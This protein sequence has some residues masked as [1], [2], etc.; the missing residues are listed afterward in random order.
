VVC[1]CLGLADPRT[2]GSKNPGTTNV[3]RMAGKWPALLTLMGDALKGL[4]PVWLVSVYFEDPLMTSVT[5]LVAVLGH[6]YPLY[7]R[8]Q[9][10]KGVATTLG[11]LFGISWILGLAAV[12][13]WVIVAL[14]FRYS[15]LAALVAVSASEE[16]TSEL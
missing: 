5:A 11:T 9:G 12:G 8:F 6:C 4:M 2:V 13:I 3:L 14:L 7:Y 10:G 16:H 1:R 15:S